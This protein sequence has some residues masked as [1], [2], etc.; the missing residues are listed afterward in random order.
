M[1]NTCKILQMHFFFSSGAYD[2]G[3]NPAQEPQVDF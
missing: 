2:V 3:A 1:Q